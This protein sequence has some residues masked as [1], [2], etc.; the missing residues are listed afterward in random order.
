ML[1]KKEITEILREERPYLASEYGVKRIGLFGSYARDVPTETSD[2][3]LVVEF[4]RPIGFRF[5]EFAEYLEHL[6]GKKVDIL[7]PAGIQGIRVEQ[8][9]ERIEESI[10]YV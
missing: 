6:L 3:D 4:D 2:V 1:T 7:T 8:V 5:T 9:A 10:V